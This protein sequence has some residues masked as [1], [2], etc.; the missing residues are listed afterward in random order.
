MHQ[1]GVEGDQ[2]AETELPG[3]HPPTAEIEGQQRGQRADHGHDRQHQGAQPGQL[4]IPFQVFVVERRETPTVECAQVAGADHRLS[5]NPLLHRLTD[6]AETF[7]YLGGMMQQAAADPFDHHQ[8]RRIG[9]QGDQGQPRSKGKEHGQGKEIDQ[10]GVGQSQHTESGHHTDVGEI[11]GEAGEQVAGALGVKEG[12]VPVEQAGQQLAAQIDFD[13]PGGAQKAQPGKLPRPPAQQG[14]AGEDGGEPQQ[15]PV[16]LALNGVDPPFEHPGDDHGQGIG[17]HQP[18]H[19]GQQ[20]A[21]V[22]TQIGKKKTQAF[23]GPGTLCRSAAR[24]TKAP[25]HASNGTDA[26]RRLLL[27][28]FADQ[29]VIRRVG[30][31]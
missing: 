24:G 8:H 6:P 13:A 26:S 25:F 10:H 7:L 21:A 15:L 3:H 4:Q 16:T 23:H 22:V 19:P 11:V 20:P 27:D 14:G 5:G 30:D 18:D 9:Q 28:D 2:L 17:Q 12:R 31:A 1:I 29:V